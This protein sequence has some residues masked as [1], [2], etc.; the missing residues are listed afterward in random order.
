M[1]LH[2]QGNFANKTSVFQHQIYNIGSSLSTSDTQFQTILTLLQ[3]EGTSIMFWIRP[4]SQG[5]SADYGLSLLEENLE[6]SQVNYITDDSGLAIF[7]ILPERFCRSFFIADHFPGS[8][9]SNVVYILPFSLQPQ[10]SAADGSDIG[11]LTLN[12]NNVLMLTSGASGTN[13]PYSLVVFVKTAA[14]LT[15]DSMGNVTLSYQ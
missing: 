7:Q 3:G 8:F 11:Y 14:F 9:R 13:G 12:N 5:G 4:S 6:L 15:E 2:R 10:L 1:Q